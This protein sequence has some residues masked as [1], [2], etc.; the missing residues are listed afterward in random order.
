[1]VTGEVLVVG[2]LQDISRTDHQRRSELKRTSSSVVLPVAFQGRTQTGLD[3]PGCDQL[4]HG[5]S[6]RAGDFG[7][8]AVLIEQHGERNAL[9]LD[10][11]LGVSLAPG[12]DGRDRCTGGDDVFVSVADLTGPLTAGQ[13]T[14]MPKEEDDL[15]LFGPQV[16][17]ANRIL[18]RVDDHGVG[19]R[20]HVE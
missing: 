7:S 20:G 14:K 16:A 3:L 6:L 10:E 4:A 17:E 8:K 11:G 15:S 18:V 5:Q 2:V 13:S 9:V 1:M 19:Q 12:T